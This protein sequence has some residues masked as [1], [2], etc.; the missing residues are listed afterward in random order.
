MATFRP[1]P[2]AYLTGKLGQGE[3]PVAITPPDGGGKFLPDG[4]VLPFPGNTIICHIDRD[5][6]AFRAMVEIQQALQAGP[7][8][9][10]FFF[11]PRSSLHMTIFQGVSGPNARQNG[12][13]PAGLSRDMPLER[14][15]VN[16]LDR[17]E[18]VRVPSNRR[19]S[20]RGLHAGH[21]L[22]MEGASPEDE[23]GLRATRETLRGATGIS[24]ENFDR[25]TFHITL[26]YL[27]RWL[28]EAE[29]R[30]VIALSES[31]YAA[32][33]E[34]LQDISLGALEICSFE[35]MYHFKPVALL[36]NSGLER[37]QGGAA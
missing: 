32:H 20:C 4:T 23:A 37:Q 30:Q 15:T 3:H 10:N 35:T 24:P 29:A 8:A 28:D 7:C 12:Q 2:L 9:G 21:S 17:L 31:L 19:V 27:A 36:G 14:V 5:S 34:N 33:K 13:W 16:L 11:L 1:D 25:Y 6:R 26:A 22:T 18:G